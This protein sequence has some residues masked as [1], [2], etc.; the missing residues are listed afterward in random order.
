MGAVV[1][2]SIPLGCPAETGAD[3]SGQTYEEP[4]GIKGFSLG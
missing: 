2:E 1:I 3:R 4:Q